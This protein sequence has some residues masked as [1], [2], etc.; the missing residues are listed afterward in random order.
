[1]SERKLSERQDSGHKDIW[2]DLPFRLPGAAKPI[3][4]WDEEDKNV[5]TS[6]YRGDLPLLT[7]ILRKILAWILGK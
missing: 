1:M 7:I 3:D 4:W 5:T 6:I 2:S